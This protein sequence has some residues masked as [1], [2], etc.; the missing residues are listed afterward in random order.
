MIDAL[1]AAA[2]VALDAALVRLIVVGH[3]PLATAPLPRLHELAGPNA[4]PRRLSLGF[5][6]NV[7]ERVTA[8]RILDG[9][10]AGCGVTDLWCRNW[11]SSCK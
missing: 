10:V 4:T 9:E 6:V 2:D 5:L 3:D 8:I 1:A 11:I 7:V